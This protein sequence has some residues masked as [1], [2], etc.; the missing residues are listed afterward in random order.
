MSTAIATREYTPEQVALIK[1]TIC[2]GATDDELALFIQQARR[3][4]LDPFSKQIHAV[5]RWDA[6]AQR[7]VMSIQVGI[8]GLRLVA[9]RTGET[10]GQ[11]GPYWC[12]P[13][14]VWKDV[15]LEQTPP[16]AAK[17]TVYR[18]GQQ[19]GYTGI[20]RWTEYAQTKKDGG[21]IGLWP[22]MPATM[23]AKCAESL[24][25]RKAFPAELS[26]IYTA[27]EMPADVDA[28]VDQPPPARQLPPAQTQP[29]PQ[30]QPRKPMTP[31]EFAAALAKRDGELAAAGKTP[32]GALIQHIQERGFDQA[33]L[34][35]DIATW[36]ADEI[37]WAVMEAASFVKSLK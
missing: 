16:A 6:K 13:D 36:P 15:W 22:K 27:D 19:R 28:P 1:R 14:G 33:G 3:T 5:K 37:E 29:A 10:D 21:L 18:K 31:A 2:Q 35:A 32:P 9:E 30:Q 12:G 4:G 23:L 8:D 25:I 24:G 34:S 26:G 17:V 11:D 7:E 20:A